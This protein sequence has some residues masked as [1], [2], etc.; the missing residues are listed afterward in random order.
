M[1]AAKPI[2]TFFVP[3]R[4]YVPPRQLRLGEDHDLPRRS[5]TEADPFRRAWFAFVR[6]GVFPSP[7]KGERVEFVGVACDAAIVKE[8]RP[9]M[10][11]TVSKRTARDE[12]G[13]SYL[14]SGNRTEAR[15]SS[16]RA[17]SPYGAR[18]AVCRR[19]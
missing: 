13:Y 19:P 12:V 11:V 17:S 8:E 10:A 16:E 4:G 5:K 2:A 14:Q 9:P 1:I 15:R 18:H 7:L 3:G 6:R